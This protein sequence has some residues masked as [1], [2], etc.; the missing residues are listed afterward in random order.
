[1]PIRPRSGRTA[2]RAPQKIVLQF[3]GGRLF[4]PEHLAPL[5]IDAGHDVPDGAVLAGGVHPL[6]DQQQ[7]V[8]VGRVVETL[9][10]TQRLD[11]FSQKFSI[12]LLRLAEGLQDR[13]PLFEYDLLSGPHT[14]IFGI[15]FHLSS[16]R[17]G[18]AS[19]VVRVCLFTGFILPNLPLRLLPVRNSSNP[20]FVEFIGSLG[21]LRRQIGR[22]FG[23]GVRK[24]AI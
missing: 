20:L 12:S 4:E 18:N 6:K 21:D 7:R 9:Q 13:R 15:D 11:V 2:G 14:E 5:R 22:L 8:T 17:K 19:R 23:H 16:F 24:R 3:L 10:F 1:M